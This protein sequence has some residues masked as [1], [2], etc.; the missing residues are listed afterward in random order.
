[1]HDN[2]HI[3]LE[4]TGDSRSFNPRDCLLKLELPRS[5]L[6]NEHRNLEFRM[7]A[8]LSSHALYDPFHQTL[9]GLNLTDN[10]VKWSKHL[11]ELFQDEFEDPN[12]EIVRLVSNSTG[13]VHAVSTT[14]GTVSLLDDSNDGS[15]LITRRVLP[16]AGYHQNEAK[17]DIDFVQK[18]L[19]GPQHDKDSLIVVV[20]PRGKQPQTVILV[21]NIPSDSKD[22]H[23]P[24]HL[25]QIRVLPLMFDLKP[26]T[27]K[28]KRDGIG[29]DLP[30]SEENSDDTG[31]IK[32][33]KGYFSQQTDTSHSWEI[34]FCA[35]VDNTTISIHQLSNDKLTVVSRNL[36]SSMLEV[37]PVEESIVQENVGLVLD[38]IS[39]NGPILAFLLSSTNHNGSYSSTL[40]YIH[41]PSLSHIG[42]INEWNNLLRHAKQDYDMTSEV[43]FISSIVPLST[44][45]ITQ[46]ENM[47][48]MAFALREVNRGS[49]TEEKLSICCVQSVLKVTQCDLIEAEHGGDLRTS[50]KIVEPH[51]V[52]YIPVNDNLGC[53][54]VVSFT[55]ASRASH[56]YSYIMCSQSIDADSSRSHKILKASP[57]SDVH[58]PSSI[59]S[60]ESSLECLSFE[61]CSA[62]QI[63]FFHGIV[64]LGRFQEAE[65]MCLDEY[66]KDSNYLSTKVHP[67]F[68]ALRQFLSLMNDKIKDAASEKL[69]CNCLTQ[70]KTG[71]IAAT[72]VGMFCLL[73]AARGVSEWACKH[74]IHVPLKL[75]RRGVQTVLTIIND[76]SIVMGGEYQR[77]LKHMRKHLEN[78]LATIKAIERVNAKFEPSQD[79]LRQFLQAKTFKSLFST[80]VMCGKSRYADFLLCIGQEYIG[81]QCLIEVIFQFPREENSMSLS[82]VMMWVQD[83]VV[84]QVKGV[85]DPRWIELLHWAC[86]AAQ[87]LD[88]KGEDGISAAISLLDTVI[89]CSAKLSARPFLTAKIT[90]GIGEDI[91]NKQ[92]ESANRKIETWINPNSS[93]FEIPMVKQ[94]TVYSPTFPE[95]ELVDAM[96]AD[97]SQQAYDAAQ[98]KLQDAIAIRDARNLGLPR[99][100]C[101]LG[102]FQGAHFLAT[103][104]LRFHIDHETTETSG[105]KD[106]VHVVV[107]EK[108]GPYCDRHGVSLDQVVLFHANESMNDCMELFKISE[109]SDDPYSEV[110]ITN[111]MTSVKGNTVKNDISSCFRILA[112]VSY[113]IECSMTVI[114]KSKLISQLLRVARMLSGE[115]TAKKT[116]TFDLESLCLRVIF[117]CKSK[118]HIE[119]AAELEESLRLLQVDHILC[120]YCGNEARDWFNVNDTDHGKTLIRHVARFLEYKSVVDDIWTLCGAFVNCDKAGVLSD[121]LFRMMSTTREGMASEALLQI[122][123]LDKEVGIEVANLA[124]Y[125]AI[126]DIENFCRMI[127]IDDIQKDQLNPRMRVAKTC[128]AA[129]D[130]AAIMKDMVQVHTNISYF[131][132]AKQTFESW[133]TCWIELCRLR[134]LQTTHGIYIS[135]STLR[136]E[137]NVHELL[138]RM[139][140]PTIE[141]I[142]KSKGV[143]FD[144]SI[145]LRTKLATARQACGTLCHD[146]KSFCLNWWQTIARAASKLI[147]CTDDDSVTH[148]FLLVSGILDENTAAVSS[149]ST[150]ITSSAITRVAIALVDR[151][152]TLVDKTKNDSSF[153]NDGE[154]SPSSPLKLEYQIS[155]EALLR[156][157][158]LIVRSAML[159]EHYSLVHSADNLPNT[160]NVSS[161]ID[162]ISQ[163]LLRAD[164]GF[165]EVLEAKRQELWRHTNLTKKDKNSPSKS[166]PA[167]LPIRKLHPTWY[168]GDGLLLPPAQS[169]ALSLRAWNQSRPSH[170]LHH[171]EMIDISNEKLF[172][173]SILAKR[174]LLNMLNER[175]AHNLAIRL[176]ASSTFEAVSQCCTSRKTSDNKHLIQELSRQFET[177]NKYLAERSLGGSGTGFMSG[178]VDSQLS[179]GY[180]LALPLKVGF[181]VRL[182]RYHS[183]VFHQFSITF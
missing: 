95:R 169:L 165:G 135:L 11:S 172:T 176:L 82:V 159:L 140:H 123:N 103:E 4:K 146:E 39:Q 88:A 71:A 75:V 46:H 131:A 168:D 41:L 60:V 33:L 30:A 99:R 108:I 70:L 111:K 125:Y 92:N 112:K 156:P 61:P 29:K 43:A 127:E 86:R 74:Q 121:L 14:L 27:S 157:M 107:H 28:V 13:T 54:D 3:S 37:D 90:Q 126:R 110:N 133:N 58:S 17:I 89:E 44:A 51:S 26:E 93:I 52:F 79:E 139:L 21:H 155:K 183:S 114:T 1:M 12:F 62:Q 97:Q 83:I 69:I 152:S 158:S 160:S 73:D 34:R 104:L 15:I 177:T 130:I 117:E 23:S 72:D 116:N 180:L 173:D 102:S 179:V 48:G 128:K 113:L 147:N 87:A 175:G 7:Q 124:V 18:S 53:S 35:L 148:K 143:G 171:N 109:C 50:L 57:Q 64:A 98:R 137:S 178:I 96:S 31:Q 149:H 56:K 141:A 68:V 134:R 136:Q 118:Q 45:S 38:M 106:F 55:L 162:L 36:L 65:L 166:S 16:E 32:Q 163:V 144:W 24:I 77:K 142:S 120:R 59:K 84:P 181:K 78:Q 9:H 94:S 161:L 105:M 132:R 6:S 164:K 101:S 42:F 10:S 100:L 115:I 154:S 167:L 2:K 47:I 153:S 119:I 5:A 145:R 182:I 67:S 150:E 80:M 8:I 91:H 174:D 19:S 40:Q 49:L 20:P 170:G 129:L 22:L 122:L 151:A 85:K 66:S 76:A 63:G 81:L 25:S 138:E